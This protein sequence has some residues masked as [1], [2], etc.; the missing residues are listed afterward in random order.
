MKFNVVQS[1]IA[2]SSADAIALPINE[3]LREAPGISEAFFKAAGKK[4]LQKACEDIGFC[5]VG[6]AVPTL[7]YK[8]KAN[9][10]IHTAVPLWID[11]E[12][13][14]YE[15]LASSYVS[16]MQIAD[17]MGCETLVIPLLT[18]EKDGFDKARSIS[19]AE[20]AISDF[21]GRNLKKIALII[22]GSHA[23]NLYRS[24]V[25][26]VFTYSK[27]NGKTTKLIDTHESTRF[28]DDSIKSFAIRYSKQQIK[29]TAD[30]FLAKE[31]RGKII[32]CGIRIAA[33]LL[34]NPQKK[35]K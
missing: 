19:V 25:S 20:K 32:A 4:H 26:T 7:A 6:N 2:K 9:Y 1:K 5:A 13:E 18:G 29:N 14:E 30:W 21:Y 17:V 10:I 8:L 11:G 16:A 24:S 23:E 34:E 35:K 31:N 15:I 27:E 22:K 12:H 33:A 28:N 3:R